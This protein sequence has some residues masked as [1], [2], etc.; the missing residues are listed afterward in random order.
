[1][2]GKTDS[3]ALSSIDQSQTDMHLHVTISPRWCSPFSQF[4]D[5]EGHL[6]AGTGETSRGETDLVLTKVSDI[7]DSRNIRDGA[8]VR[9]ICKHS[10]SSH[11]KHPAHALSMLS[12]PR[13]ARILMSS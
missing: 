11:N 8:I 6:N 2:I 3:L 7:R 13:H 1:M 4:P 9:S 10:E 12:Q 5:G